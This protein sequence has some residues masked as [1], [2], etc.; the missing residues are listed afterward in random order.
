MDCKFKLKLGHKV[1]RWA[2]SSRSLGYRVVNIFINTFYLCICTFSEKVKNCL[3]GRTPLTIQVFCPV[4][5]SILV[6]ATLKVDL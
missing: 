2:K 3:K 4:T 5:F 6:R 1:V